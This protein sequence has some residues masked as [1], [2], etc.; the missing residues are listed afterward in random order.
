M[1]QKTTSGRSSKIKLLIPKYKISRSLI[2][3]LSV[4]FFLVIRKLVLHSFMG[5]KNKLLKSP[6]IPP[7]KKRD[8]VSKI[9]PISTITVAKAHSQK[10]PKDHQSPPPKIETS[11]RKIRLWTFIP[12]RTWKIRVQKNY[13]AQ[14]R[15]QSQKVARNSTLATITIR[16]IIYQ[17]A[18]D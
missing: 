8:S 5:R 7:R 17:V 9:H 15:H 14:V 3:C 13:L 11:S 12:V 2:N 1:S 18:K 6:V 4:S 16:R 10:V